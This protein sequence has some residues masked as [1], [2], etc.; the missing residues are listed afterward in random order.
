MCEQEVVLKLKSTTWVLL[1]V[2][3]ILAG[4]LIA[5]GGRLWRRITAPRIERDVTSAP[6]SAVTAPEATTPAVGVGWEAKRDPQSG[7]THLVPPPAEEQALREAFA[8]LLHRTRARQADAGALLTYARDLSVAQARALVADGYAWPL[9]DTQFVFV[10]TELGPE[11]EVRCSDATHCR[12]TQA[13]LGIESVL[14]FDAAMCGS[15][16]ST[17][18]LAP[19][20]DEQ[21]DA[22]DNL[23]TADFRRE[24]D[25]AW[26]LV[27]WETQPLPVL[28]AGW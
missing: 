8:V 9:L 11:N 7:R 19:L 14:I 18:C 26:R 2:V 21:I 17:P 24:D 6:T 16:E 10:Y 27:A 13:V 1:A 3:V 25:G 5:G 12:V 28:P 22:R 23:V 20:S 15:P 4:M